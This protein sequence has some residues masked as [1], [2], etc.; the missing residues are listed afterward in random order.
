VSAD[1][2][3]L[4]VREP[5]P[6]LSAPEARALAEIRSLSVDATTPIEALNLLVKLKHDLSGG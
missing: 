5:A 6:S 2:L 3:G 4:F 1:Q